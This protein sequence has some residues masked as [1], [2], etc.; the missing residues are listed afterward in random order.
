M[1][2]TLR[3]DLTAQE[4]RE[5][6]ISGSI[7]PDERGYL[8]AVFAPSV[9]EQLNALFARHIEDRAKEYAPVDRR[10]Q[11][12][13]E[14]YEGQSGKG[15]T[16]TIP[17]VKRDANQQLA[18]LLNTL[19]SKEPLMSVVP[20]ESGSVQVI[21]QD[22]ETGETVLKMVSTEEEADALEAL[23]NFYLENRVGFRR[24]IRAFIAELLR[25]GNRPPILKVV[26]DPQERMVGTRNVVLKDNSDSVIERIEKDPLYKKVKSGE[27]TRIELIPGDKFFVPFPH[28]DI[29]QAPFV[30]QEFEEDT[31]TLKDKLA[32]GVYDLCKEEAPTQD[33]IDAILSGVEPATAKKDHADGR[34]VID[35][36]KTHTLYEIW[37]D[38]PFAEAVSEP[39]LDE[40]GAPVLDETGQ[41]VTNDTV[42]V[43]MRPFCSVFHKN[44]KVF[45]NTYENF[46]WHRQRPFHAGRMQERPFSFS[47][48][49][50][51]E[52]V[53]PFQRLISQLFHLQTQ[54]LVQSNVKVFMVRNGTSTMKFF[55]SGGK[56]RPGVIIPFDDK[57]DVNPQ[58]LGSPV[59]SMAAEISFLNGEAQK[60]SVVTEYDRGA[61]PSRTPVGTVN[62]IENLAKMQPAMVLDTIRETLA[63][64]VKMFVQ[65]LI[66]FSPE[67]LVIPFKDP[68]KR[69]LVQRSIGLPKE[70]LLDQFAFRVTAT[71]EDE[72]PQAL[73]TRDLML[74][75]EQQKCLKAVQEL[76][77]A[78]VPGV[79]PLHA[80]MLFAQVRGTVRMYG[81]LFL[82]AKLNP[83][84]YLPSVKEIDDFEAAIMS[85]LMQPPQQGA[86]DGQLPPAGPAGLIAGGPGNGQGLGPM[87]GQPGDEMALAGGF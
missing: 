35:P 10:R 79:H 56:L 64:V 73:T 51:S 13:I 36:A 37:W 77:A 65:T 11:A 28:Y 17:V 44:A 57:D 75:S 5:D 41:P 42:T 25:D 24:I 70:V 46:Y 31:A 32:S 15:E 66:Q 26:H 63:D 40:L 34:V 78:I 84:D 53:A 4:G 22:E 1:T 18:W 21:V 12:N 8:R 2:T 76:L 81:R 85:M 30:Y 38:Y 19:F 59:G 14:A 71:A 82:H 20:L 33:E 47:A 87:E 49:S 6:G 72:T 55:S 45:L 83:D 48:Y 58:P 62:A 50:T 27:P 39:V 61:I 16:I 54:N 9:R 68:V 80:K 69:A 86:I 7:V 23:V 29:Q 52:N 43:T 60:M 74:A 67:G 3:D